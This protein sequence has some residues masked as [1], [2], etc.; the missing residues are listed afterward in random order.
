MYGII[1]IVRQDTERKKEEKAV[2]F[3]TEKYK[4]SIETFA[5]VT[6]EPGITKSKLMSVT[7]LSSKDLKEMVN[8]ELL[9]CQRIVQ[10][11]TYWMTSRGTIVYNKLRQNQ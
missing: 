1:E 11:E 5:T 6:K 7:G 10:V 8:N 4:G 2:T 9:I 3:F